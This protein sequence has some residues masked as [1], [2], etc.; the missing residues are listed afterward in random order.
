MTEKKTIAILHQPIAM[1]SNGMERDHGDRSGRA[2]MG[3]GQ[4]LMA[5]KATERAR[6]QTLQAQAAE[7][8][9]QRHEVA[10]ETKSSVSARVLGQSGSVRGDSRSP[11]APTRKEVADWFYIDAAKQQQGPFLLTQMRQWYAGGFLPD[12]TLAKHADDVKFTAV[13][14]QSRIYCAADALLAAATLRR[15]P[16]QQQ[17]TR[18]SHPQQPEWQRQPPPQHGHVENPG[19]RAA[20]EANERMGFGAARKAAAGVVLPAAK[21]E[22]KRKLK[23]SIIKTKTPSFAARVTLTLPPFCLSPCWCADFELVG[24]AEHGRPSPKPEQHG[25]DGT[26]QNIWVLFLSAIKNRYH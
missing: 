25:C 15:Q 4:I 19:Q 20:R 26:D 1:D 2:G 11:D 21:K 14:N 16:D 7:R 6:T 3:A 17:W 8:K 12:S 22:G 9:R 23:G 18:N 24:V 13:G 10:E 5:A